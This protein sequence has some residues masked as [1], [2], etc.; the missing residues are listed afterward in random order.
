MAGVQREVWLLRMEETNSRH[1][2]ELNPT[3]VLM[4]QMCGVKERRNK[5]ET[6]VLSAA[7][8]EWRHFLRCDNSEECLG[9]VAVNT[10]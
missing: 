1:V 7:P 6:Q 8:G 10:G 2:L 3:Q 4:A 9:G 5:E